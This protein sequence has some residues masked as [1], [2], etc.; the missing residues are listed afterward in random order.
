MNRDDEYWLDILG[1]N[2]GFETPAQWIEAQK[3][4]LENQKQKSEI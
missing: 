4:N 3:T 2:K 1:H